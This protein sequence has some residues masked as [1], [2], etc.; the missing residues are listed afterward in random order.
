[1]QRWWRVVGLYCALLWGAGWNTPAFADQTDP[2]LDRLFVQLQQSR[3]ESEIAGLML[4][5]SGIWAVSGSAA[6]DLLIA[7]ADE[8]QAKQA[9]D[10][11][12]EILDQVV[13]IAPKFAEGWRR[14]GALNAADG[15]DEEALSD[16]REALKLEPR[17]F[18]AL[19]QIGRLL[20]AA[21]EA[22]AALQTYQR[23][24]ELIPQ[25]EG[26]RQRIQKLETIT[27]AQPKGPSPI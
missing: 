6:I 5:I 23:L 12:M 13:A 1:M 2:R 18:G 14:R 21:G 27:G 3:S 24:S 11:A 19:E 22:G 8:A 10:V 7:R 17:H 20:E 9:P 16:L 26:L 25:A 15:N 4:Q